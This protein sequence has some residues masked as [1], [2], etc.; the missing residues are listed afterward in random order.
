MHNIH[1]IDVSI[2]IFYFIV[3]IGI[4]LYKY[5]SVNTI[6][7]K[8][9]TLGC[10]NFPDLVIVTTFFATFIGASDILGVTEKVYE[11]GIFFTITIL[12]AP[13][14]WLI[15]ARLYGK[16]IDQFIGCISI[17]DIMDK[18]YGAAG[19]W[20]TNITAIPISIVVV[21]TQSTAMGC[22]LHY[23]FSIPV[24]YCI[25][26]S[27]L[28]LALYSA[29]GGI[30]AVAY[31]DVF[32][33]TILILAIPA[34]CFIVYG[35]DSGGGIICWHKVF[36]QLPKEML[37]LNLNKENIGLFSSLIFWSL[38]P[39]TGGTFIQRFFLGKNS[40]Q[41][42]RCL[43]F[44]PFLHLF[45]IVIV[46]LIG[47][48]IKA[49][50]PNI[51]PNTTFIYFVSNYLFVGVKGLVIAGLLAIIM[52]TADSWLNTTSVLFTYDII[53][54]IIYLNK[55]QLLIIARSSTFVIAIIAIIISLSKRGIME[56][57]WLA[58]NFWEP[59]IIV[60][61][62]A[63]FLKFWTNSKSLIASVVLAT[64]FTCIGKY[65]VGEFATISV[66]FGII[67]SA[68]G[69]FGMHYLQGIDPASKHKE[70][71]SIEAGKKKGYLC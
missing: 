20:I 31:T 70:L 66:M 43:K 17:S 46:C 64:I 21:A 40:R 29:F 56:L 69:L 42:T 23:F 3:C 58:G 27:T 26:T 62:T 68:I 32:Q 19:R 7:V 48:F 39:L 60:P 36:N 15:T 4:G 38:L 28:I 8:E 24:H 22:L 53:G 9:Y 65:I 30:R 14:F 55:R 54:K 25:I 12:L 52:S 34:S 49:K 18:L 41:L 59:F 45:F 13:F 10:R 11:L 37:T 63:G 50:A 5:K 47:F 51:D 57:N 35:I 71:A 6:K 61:L 2:V 67:G 33:F 1:I 16:N 44:I